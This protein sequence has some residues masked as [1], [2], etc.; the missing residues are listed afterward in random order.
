MAWDLARL[1]IVLVALQRLGELVLAR[2]NTARLLAAGAVEHG[3]GHYPVMVTLHLAWLAALLWLAP[4]PVTWGWIAVFVVLQA[5]RVWVIA[6]LG[7]R[8]TT[9]IIAVPGASLVRS[10]PYRFLRHPNYVIVALEIP[11]LPLALDLP[12]AALV[13]GVANLAVLAWRIR[14]E[15][16]ALSQTAVDQ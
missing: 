3:A 9:R 7:P 15:D 13:F 6:T 14:T 16:A 5:A 4:G 12:W 8:W 10:G 2:R 11:I 1:I